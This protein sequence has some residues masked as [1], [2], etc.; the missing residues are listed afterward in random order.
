[1]TPFFILNYKQHF[2]GL[3]KL[4]R[5]DCVHNVY[6]NIVMFLLAIYHSKIKKLTTNENISCTMLSIND[7]NFARVFYFKTTLI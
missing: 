5:L 7:R 4:N 3:S 6:L 2:Y 1:M